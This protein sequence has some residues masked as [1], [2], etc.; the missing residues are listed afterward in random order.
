MTRT[1]VNVL[2]DISIGLTDLNTLKNLMIAVNILLGMTRT[3]I[4][5]LK[6]VYICSIRIT[7]PHVVLTNTSKSA[8]RVRFVS[9]V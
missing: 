1:P 9:S 5:V 3:R 8:V 7:L 4:N 6:H 2:K